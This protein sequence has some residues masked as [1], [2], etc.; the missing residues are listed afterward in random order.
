M[1][2]FLVIMGRLQVS[3]AV[4]VTLLTRHFRTVPKMLIFLSKIST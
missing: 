1:V 2:L 4:C 3:V